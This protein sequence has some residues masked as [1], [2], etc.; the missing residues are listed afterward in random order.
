M[1]QDSNQTP[2]S[3]NSTWFLLVY[4]FLILAY[5]VP[6]FQRQKADLEVRRQGAVEAMKAESSL[7]EKP[8]STSM[9]DAKFGETMPPFSAKDDEKQL[10]GKI[11]D[12]RNLGVQLNQEMQ[13]FRT[14]EQRLQMARTQE[15]GA[16]L[17]TE[18]Q[19][20]VREMESGRAIYQARVDQVEASLKELASKPDVSRE[21]RLAHAFIQGELGNYA[22]KITVMEA[23]QKQKPLSLQ[24]GLDLVFTYEQVNRLSEAVVTLENLSKLPDLSAEEA[25]Q[26][27]AMLAQQYFWTEE[28]DKALAVYEEL[29][30][31][32]SW[33]S[34]IAQPKQNAM[35]AKA[36]YDQ[37]MEYRKSDK[38]HPRAEIITGKGRILVE[39]FEDDAPNAVANFI[40]LAE[41]KFYDG[42]KF[43]RVIPKFMAQGGDPNSK[44]EDPSND[45]SGGPGYTIKTE[46]SKRNHMRGSLSYANAGINT[47]GSQ[48]FVTVVPT[49]WLNGKHAVFGRVLEGMPVVDSLIVGDEIKNVNILSKR[50]KEYTVTKN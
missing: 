18:Y 4:A 45:G 36:L 3:S 5:A 15:E 48:F 20:K 43:H 11:E 41:A 42:Q 13:Q 1:S 26:I 12:I 38:D 29:S 6:E 25:P 30:K 47:D 31:V 49:F 46:I 10:L 19:Q 21:V 44:D 7:E 8:Q 23:E 22:E 2:A 9:A 33:A 27:K 14:L 50:N 35:E 24:E 37:E 32:G 16:K 39:L 40:S 28:F 34:L 17:Y